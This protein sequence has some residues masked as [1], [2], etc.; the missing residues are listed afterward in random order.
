MKVYAFLFYLLF[1]HPVKLLLPEGKKKELFLKFVKETSPNTVNEDLLY[2]SELESIPYNKDQIDSLIQ[3]YNFPSEYNFITSVGANVHIKEQ[4]NCGSCWAFATT[5]TLAYRYFLKGIDDDFSPQHE[6]SCYIPSCDHGNSMIDA[7]LSF[8]K[9]GTITEECLPY[10][11]DNKIIEECPKA[12]K[13]PNIEYKKYY[14]KNAYYAR[15]DQSNIY[16]ITAIIMDQLLTKGPVTTRITVYRDF[17]NFSHDPNCQNM[18]Y[19][20]DGVSEI[21]GGHQL[22]IVGYGLLN[23]KYYW[24]LQNSWGIDSC[25]TGFIKVEFG[26]VG[27]GTF[28]F[29]EPYIEEQSTEIM[30]IQY[31]KMNSDCSLEITS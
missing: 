26:Q 15:L 1:F 17:V 10:S 8:V 18:V 19:S 16:E 11:V 2:D 14:A 23:N 9:N 24:L 22:V 5:T 13:D 30:N 29:S 25:Q 12:C 28:S 27:V 31:A 6:L 21:G 4:K 20:Y 7:Q 3:R